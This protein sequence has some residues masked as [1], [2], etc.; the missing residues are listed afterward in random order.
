MSETVD[1]EVRDRSRWAALVASVALVVVACTA[2]TP[3]TPGGA[4]PSIAAEPTSSPVASPIGLVATTEPADAPPA[5]SIRVSMTEFKFEPNAPKV[6]TGTVS[7][8]LENIDR[9]TSETRHNLNIGPELGKPLA[10]STIVN[11]GDAAV[12]T[13]E[14][15]L[16]GTYAIWC[17]LPQHTENGMVGTLTVSR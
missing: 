7:F 2:A 3:A 11:A 6:K 17:S 5:G 4:S 9:V 14:D 8:F 15:L 16:P 12:F 10:R 1:P 13:V